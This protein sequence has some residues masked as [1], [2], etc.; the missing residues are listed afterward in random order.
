MFAKIKSATLYG[1]DA[2][3]VNVE[4]DLAKGLPGWQIVGLPEM[5][6]RESKERVAAAI[7]NSGFELATRKTTINLAPADVKK[8]GTAFDL[9]I[10]IGLLC[11]AGM[12]PPERT[13]GWLFAGELSLTSALAPIPGVISYAMA[14]RDFK[15]QGIILPSTNLHEASLVKGLDIIGA[16]TLAE[17]V[18]FLKNGERPKCPQIKRENRKFFYKYDFSDIKSQHTAKRA[19]EIAAAGNHHIL[20]HGPP[21]TGK[22]MLAERIP[23]IVPELNYEEALEVTRIYSVSGYINRKNPLFTE[24]PFR[25]PHHSASYAGLVGGGSGIPK[26]GEISLAHRGILFMDE[27]PEF[28]K[29][30]LESLR[31]PLECGRVNITRSHASITYPAQFMFVAAMNPCKCGFFGHPTKPCICS[32]GQIQNYRRKISGPLLD[33]LDLHVSVPPVKPEDLQ[34]NGGGESSAAIRER[35]LAARKKQALRYKKIGLECNSELGSRELRDFCR[36]SPECVSFLAKLIEKMSLSARAYD[37][38][39]RVSRTIADLSEEEQIAITHLL[40]AA[41]YRSFDREF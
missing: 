15:L 4:V 27:L 38:I 33:R 2:L 6:I 8:H 9:P 22:T 29:D 10:A 23:T 16:D 5:M 36:L 17:V 30:V 20:L 13:A 1:I 11:A 34:K 25:A 31:Q 26:P 40:E 19:V 21:G 35:V 14:S 24:R 37:R 18:N 12:Y 3:M 32:I 41:Q 39:L 7:R 28:K